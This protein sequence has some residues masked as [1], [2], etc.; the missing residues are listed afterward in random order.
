[1]SFLT[2][3]PI[4]LMTLAAS[5]AAPDR[6]ALVTFTGLVRNHHAGRQVV[7]LGYTAYGE[8]AEK[9]CGEIAREAQ[10]R[11]QVQV[12]L[13]HRLGELAIGDTAVAVAVT[14]GHRGAGFDACRWVIDALK[15]QVPIWKRERYADGTE[16]WVDPTA[17]NGLVE[18][19]P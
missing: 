15:S 5:I 10:D 7:S 17:P 1:M 12:A 11:W 9:I 14:A 2:T 13:A 8:M 19:R 6:G 3:Q 18:A 4:D 16:A